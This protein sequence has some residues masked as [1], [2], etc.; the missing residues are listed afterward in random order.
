MNKY[1]Y[2]ILIT[3]FLLGGLFFY[4]SS[5]FNDGKL[6]LVVCDVG[7][8]DGILIKTPNGSD[9]LVDGGPDDSILSCL[10]NNMPFWDRTIEAIILTHPDADHISGVVNVIERYNVTHLFTQSNPGK[11]L[12]YKRFKQALEESSITPKFVSKGDRI[13]F[14]DGTYFNVLWPESTVPVNKQNPALNEFSVI[15]V[16]NYGEFQALLTGDAGSKVMDKISA[17][18][19]DIDVLKVPHHGSKTGMSDYFLSEIKPSLAIISVGAK[20]S[21]GHPTKVALDLLNTHNIQYLRTDIQG[22]IEIISNGK[23]FKIY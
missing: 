15:T 16:L 1:I 17:L 5:R 11:T 12:I 19:G 2:L 10:T 14:K 22:E 9:I 21:Y 23:G 8:G 3:L 20:N 18:A 13:G 7:Q 6:H 4:E